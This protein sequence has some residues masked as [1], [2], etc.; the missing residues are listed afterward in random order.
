MTA[1]GFEQPDTESTNEHKR[2]L[3]YLGGGSG[4]SACDWCIIDEEGNDSERRRWQTLDVVP[5]Q[6]LSLLIFV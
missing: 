2:R 6:S 3:C 4:A 1:D 5:L